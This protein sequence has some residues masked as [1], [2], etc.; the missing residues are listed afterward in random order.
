MTYLSVHTELLRERAVDPLTR[1]LPPAA[2]IVGGVLAAGLIG[3]TFGTPQ[4]GSSG[5]A[6]AAGLPSASTINTTLIGTSNEPR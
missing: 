2:L 4:S 3:A 5:E 6:V 1:W